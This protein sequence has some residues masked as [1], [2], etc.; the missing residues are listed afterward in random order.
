MRKAFIATLAEIAASDERVM[1]LTADLGFM[2]LEPFRNQF[3]DRLINVGVMEQNMIALATGLALQGYIPF[4]Y[5][6]ATFA[7]MRSYEFIRNGPAAH[8]LPVRIVGI[9]TG[10]DYSFDGLS[11][12]AL[13]DISLM[14]TLPNVA[15]ISP[16]DSKQTQTALRETWNNPGPIYY[17]LSKNDLLNVP[18]LRGTYSYKD[19][20]LLK[21]G[22]DGILFATGS[23]TSDV[24][25]AAKILGMRGIDCAVALISTIQP[26]DTKQLAFLLSGY[27]YAFSYEPSSPIGGIGSI[28]AETIAEYNLGVKLIRNGLIHAPSATLGSQAFMHQRN[29]LD[30]QSIV[31]TVGA[32]LTNERS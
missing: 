29:F 11:H 1:L 5:S 21:S 30:T 3:P 25:E 9:G 12:Y 22:K 28:V 2:V 8:N 17:R 7:T 27:S 19:M 23:V 14:R 15:I 32:H 10:V 13:E 24:L 31:D 16:A 4:A 26:F 18:V 20:Q 6:I